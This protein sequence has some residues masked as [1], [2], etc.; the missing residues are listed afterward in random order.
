M[1]EHN[2]CHQG[3]SDGRERPDRQDERWGHGR[4]NDQFKEMRRQRCE[5]QS[6]GRQERQQ[7]TNDDDDVGSDG[8]DDDFQLVQQRL[9]SALGMFSD[10]N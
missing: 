5:G 1:C 8:D 7:A 3:A 9:K 10:P 6:E 4:G 2:A